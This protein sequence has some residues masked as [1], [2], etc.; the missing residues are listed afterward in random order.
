MIRNGCKPA[1]YVD[2][3]K[4]IYHSSYLCRERECGDEEVIERVDIELFFTQVNLAGCIMCTRWVVPLWKSF[5]DIKVVGCGYQLGCGEA[6]VMAQQ[7]SEYHLMNF[8][9]NLFHD[10][11]L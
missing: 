5:V 8:Q 9:Q 6:A 11:Y 2:T 1:Q 3:L 7:Q 10:L 4:N